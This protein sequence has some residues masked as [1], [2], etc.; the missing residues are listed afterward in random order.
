MVQQMSWSF[1]NLMKKHQDII[2]LNTGWEIEA[3]K[4]PFYFM[5]TGHHCIW[6]CHLNIEGQFRKASHNQMSEFVY[7]K[8]TGTTFKNSCSCKGTTHPLT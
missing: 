7:F 8:I 4:S 6:V 2:W 3:N 5:D 1:R